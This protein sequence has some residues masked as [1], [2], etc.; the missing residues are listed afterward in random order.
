ML[1]DVPLLKF[2]DKVLKKIVGK[3]AIVTM[4]TGSGKTLVSYGWA[5]SAVKEYGKIII[6][7]PTKAIS[8]ERYQNLKR[9][10]IDAGLVTGD[11]KTSFDSDIICMTQE[12]YY[13]G[14][15]N[16]VAAVVIDEFHY[17]FKN[18]DR[19]RCYIESIAMSNPKSKILLMSA[20]ISN[21]DELANWLNNLTG[22]NFITASTGQRLVPLKYDYDG[23]KAKDLSDSIVFAFSKKDIHR[24]VDYIVSERKHKLANR[25]IKEINDICY[26]YSIDFMPE[27]EHGISPYYGA[28][29]P[30]EKMII[31]YMFREGIVDI[32]VGTDAL[33]LGINTPAKYSVLSTYNK[34]DG[35]MLS[36]SEFNQLAGRA[37]RYG[38]HDIGISTYLVDS[39]I[40]DKNLSDK[41][42]YLTRKPI[43][44]TTINID[45]DIAELMKGK[46]LAD[47]ID[48]I[49][50]Y[51]YSADVN[52]ATVE[53]GVYAKYTEIQNRL[54]NIKNDIDKDLYATFIS[55][56]TG[57]Y[58]D[59]WDL[60]NNITNAMIA[61]RSI[62]DLGYIDII[63]NMNAIENEHFGVTRNKGKILYDM[64]FLLKWINN[65]NNGN[66]A[67]SIKSIDGLYDYIDKLD[68]TVF[69]PDIRLF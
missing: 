68:M 62:A 46:S 35:R 67:Y 36:A 14:Y 59:E 65:I 10:G 3:D 30:K 6:T 31:D 33:A 37:G 42:R 47:E 9:K 27:W 53:N 52:E 2:Q 24:L 17:I 26:K 58:L 44:K 1:L 18:S 20:T 8:V 21:I 12:V 48:A 69:N 23:I 22:R 60:D 41:F 32:I 16:T 4:P 66:I 61:A 7:A 19:A 64:L 13:N 34:Y 25:K 63:R 38:F 43:E 39:P 5:D 49:I 29:L 40:S 54:N 56:I 11:V 55:L 45:I 15:T 28:M 50:K 51:S 57:Y